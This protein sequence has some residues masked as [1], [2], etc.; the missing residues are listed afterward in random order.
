MAPVPEILLFMLFSWTE[1]LVR[2]SI[3]EQAAGVEEGM[4]KSRGNSEPAAD[5][6]R[7]AKREGKSPGQ[8]SGLL[9][10]FLLI[11]RLFPAPVAVRCLKLF[12]LAADLCD[13]LVSPAQKGCLQAFRLEPICG[14]VFWLQGAIIVLTMPDVTCWQLL[15]VVSPRAKSVVVESVLSCLRREKAISCQSWAG[16]CTGVIP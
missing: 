14:P 13:I 5:C 15:G 7:E 12:A 1:M 16:G 6:R 11:S 9:Q 3:L 10:M 4:R 8:C 2:I